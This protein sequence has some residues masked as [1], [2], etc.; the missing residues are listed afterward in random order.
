MGRKRANYYYHPIPGSRDLVT[1]PI[2]AQKQL[3][4]IE[5]A[6]EAERVEVVFNGERLQKFQPADSVDPGALSKEL[7]G[8]DPM[9]QI[10]FLHLLLISAPRGADWC[11][12][13]MTE[14]CKRTGLS[15]RRLLR[16]LSE[17]AEGGRIKPLD[18]DR[19]GTLYKIY[20]VLISDMVSPEKETKRDKKVKPI[21][22]QKKE[23][24]ER[25]RKKSRGID[26]EKP[27]ES[28]INEEMFPSGKKVVTIK[29]IAMTFF[30]EA[31]IEHNDPQM[32]E[33]IAHITYLLEDGFSRKEVL[34]GVRF[35]ARTMKGRASI[36][37][38]PYIINQAIEE[39]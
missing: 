10:V 19:N 36:G 4:K 17:L 38:L 3:Q 33:A 15:R 13:G 26:R 32:D 18:R 7:Q 39:I 5:N 24:K 27:I 22:K 35:L 1:R 23:M 8:L 31:K 29:E 11:R 14:L 21:V 6:G 16:T 30:S 28:P 9:Q 37:R 34:A 25:S 20:S 12:V 2:G